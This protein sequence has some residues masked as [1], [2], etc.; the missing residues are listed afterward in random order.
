MK[1]RKFLPCLGCLLSLILA[2]AL[3]PGAAVAADETPVTVT[4]A[5]GTV[6]GSYATMA[7]AMDVIQDG[8]CV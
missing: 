4:G 8:R 3:L 7:E 1:K 6:R 2:L 5:D